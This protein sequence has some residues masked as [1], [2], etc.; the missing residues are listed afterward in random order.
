METMT[1]NDH[2]EI[3]AALASDVDGAFESY[4]RSTIDG[5]FTGALRMLGDHGD[6]EDVVQETYA[7]AHRALLGYDPE[8]IRVIALAAWTWT[9]RAIPGY[10][11]PARPTGRPLTAAHARS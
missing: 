7:R 11:W 4:V 3:A 2:A 5:I 10:R 9:A 6:A 1:P 8:R